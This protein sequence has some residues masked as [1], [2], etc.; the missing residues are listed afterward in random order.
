MHAAGGQYLRLGAAGAGA[1]NVFDAAPTPARGGAGGGRPRQRALRQR[2]RR[3]GARPRR[4]GPARRGDAAARAGAHAAARRLRR[5]R[6]STPRRAPPRC[7]AAS[8]TGRWRRSSTAPSDIDLDGDLCAISLRELPHEFVPAATLLIAQWLWTR[9][10]SERRRRATS[11]S[12]RWARSACTLRCASCWCS[13]RGAAAS[14]APR[15][16]WPRRTSRTCC[17]PRRARWWPPTA[18]RSCS[19]VTAPPRRRGWSSAFGLTD[20]AAPLRRARRPRRVPAPGRAAALRDPHRHAR[21]APVHPGAR[22]RLRRDPGVGGGRPHPLDVA[23]SSDQHMGAAGRATPKMWD[24]RGSHRPGQG[25]LR[26]GAQSHSTSQHQQR[27]DRDIDEG[28]PWIDLS[29]PPPTPPV[30]HGASTRARKQRGRGASA[31][32]RSS[33]L[34]G[35]PASRS[36][37]ASPARASI[38]STRWP[39]RGAAR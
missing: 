27:P 1:L 2:A 22:G 39:G 5:R 20:G 11:C 9:V 24:N 16:W 4:R 32:P 29:P 14:T 7:C 15:W 23:R 37:A 3:G 30:T 35:R 8:A 19:A 26:P 25:T 33:C 6:W 13:W 31:A 21:A 34:A 18:R 10:R 12:T 36:S 17:A 28:K 38:P